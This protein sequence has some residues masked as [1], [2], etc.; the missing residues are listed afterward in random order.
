MPVEDEGGTKVDGDK[1]LPRDSLG[2]PADGAV[3]TVEAHD[4]LSVVEEYAARIGGERQRRDA[5]HIAPKKFAG[6]GVVG[7][8]AA[9]F[10]VPDVLGRNAV[11]LFMHAPVDDAVLGAFRCF[12]A[13]EGEHEIFGDNDFLR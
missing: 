8:D 5:M 10:F 12:P 6:L 7:I 2:V 3:F 4:A 11:A 9:R 1:R 13:Y